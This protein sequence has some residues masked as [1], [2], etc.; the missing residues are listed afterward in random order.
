MLLNE[1][2][3]IIEFMI[4]NRMFTQKMI[5]CCHTFIY[6]CVCIVN[7]EFRVDE[8]CCWLVL[9]ESGIWTLDVRLL[10]VRLV[11]PCHVMLIEVSLV[12]RPLFQPKLYTRTFWY[13]GC[14]WNQRF[15]SPDLL[16]LFAFFYILQNWVG[17]IGGVL[18][19]ASTKY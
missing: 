7:L 16:R 15:E 10:A 12:S 4:H 8:A 1:T 5:K 14:L 11:P 9:I 3:V 19:R 18:Q 2:V 6:A 13:V 17:V